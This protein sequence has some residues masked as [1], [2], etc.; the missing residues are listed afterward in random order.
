MLRRSQGCDELGLLAC[1]PLE[2][3]V[4][5][6]VGD[7]VRF[8]RDLLRRIPADE[9]PPLLVDCPD[10]SGDSR[11]LPCD[12]L[13]VQPPAGI[14]A[15]RSFLGSSMISRISS[16]PSKIWVPISALR[17]RSIRLRSAKSRH[18]QVES[19]I[20]REL[21]PLTPKRRVLDPIREIRT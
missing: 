4:Q 6:A 11:K 1:E 19:A 21:E 9:P 10:L 17:Q 18:F 12:A 3:P 20:M 13:V 14:D 2:V 8:S 15:A 5:G 7:D 16:K